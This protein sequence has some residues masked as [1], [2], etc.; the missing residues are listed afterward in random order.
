RVIARAPGTSLAQSVLKKQ[1]AEATRATNSH[2][3]KPLTRARAVQSSFRTE[4]R[5]ARYQNKGRDDE[6]LNHGASDDVQRYS[7]PQS[8]RGAV[9][10][11]LRSCRLVLGVRAC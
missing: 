10:S 6:L 8:I 11:V 4:P 2:K 9:G 3:K 7:V 5:T 1:A